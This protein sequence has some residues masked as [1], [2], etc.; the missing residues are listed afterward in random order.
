MS[1]P[2]DVE[3]PSNQP[4]RLERAGHWYVKKPILRALAQGVGSFVP[5]VAAA[6]T[7]LS[8]KLSA[9]EHERT[10]TFFEELDRSDIELTPKIVASEDFLHCFTVAV[11]AARMNS[12]SREDQTARAASGERDAGSRPH[13]RGRVRGVTADTGRSVDPRDTDNGHSGSS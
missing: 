3:P 1:E 7:W 5:G 11:R 4:G 9:L 6:D 12:P 8:E 13:G 10:R 2:Q